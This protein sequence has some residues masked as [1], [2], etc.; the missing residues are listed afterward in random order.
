MTYHC[1]DNLEPAGFFRWFGEIAAIPHGS[2]REQK[3]IAFLQRFA[4]QRGIPCETDSAGNV[5][6]RLCAHP[7][8][9][10]QPAILFQAHMDMIWET[11]PGV[12]FDFENQPLALYVEGDELRAR[13]T[14]LGADNAVGMA[15][16]L[17]LAD[18]PTI[19]R[20][21]LELLFTVTEEA[22][23]IGIRAVDP[24]TIHARRMIN[25]D[26]GDSHV[27]CVSS[28]G[29]N[30]IG[31]DRSFPTEPVTGQGYTVTIDGGLGGHPGLSANQG[32]CCAA[33]ALGELLMALPEVRLSSLTGSQAIMP[34][35]EAVIVT[36][37]PELLEE[38]FALIQAVYAQTDPGLRLTVTPCK[39]ETALSA[40]DSR[41]VVLCLAHMR[42]GQHRCDG[43][44][45]RNVV[46]SGTITALS[47]AEGA[48]RLRYRLRSTIAAD[49]VLHFD[50][51]AAMAESLGFTLRS[52]DSYEGWPERQDSPFR[53]KFLRSH[54]SLFG[55]DLELERC[56]GGIETG[57]LLTKLPDM[58][59][60]GIAPTSRGAHTPNEHL[61]I[62]QVQPYWQLLLAVLGEKE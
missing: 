28:A 5:L 20:P 31:I 54:R 44:N 16:M 35:A 26:C 62:S 59:A 21:A 40:A 24:N 51:L 33:N 49:S 3:L 2:H 46:T 39:A 47:L 61:F 29:K 19:P 42:S 58:D 10:D 13:G 12:A 53:D 27:L 45:P 14:T 41:S 57:I 23:M 56:P 30:D 1:L 9:E 60:I 25:M 18:D 38:R 34:R 32:R 48:F 37:T 4:A 6:L 11:A 43:N 50:R 7:G 36:D 8:Y 55:Y 22:G 15:T 17:A 52:I